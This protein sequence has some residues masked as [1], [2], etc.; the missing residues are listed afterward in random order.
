MPWYSL[1][2]IYYGR[3]GTGLRGVFRSA[4]R[5]EDEMPVDL[6]MIRAQLERERSHL[7]QQLAQL[8]AGKNSAE[9]KRESTPFGKRDQGATET[10]ELEK[11]LTLEKRIRNQLTEVD[12]AIQKINE[13]NYGSCERCGHPIN[14]E[15]LE[16]LPTATLCMV[17]KGQVRTR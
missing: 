2:L 1:E 11:R 3:T 7:I 15:R 9:E 12:H 16:A 13:G 4:G 8:E 14:P 10:A 17:C 5:Q 6:K